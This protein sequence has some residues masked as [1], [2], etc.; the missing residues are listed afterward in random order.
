MT[1]NTLRGQ[2]AAAILA[3]MDEEIFFV[4]YRYPKA[5]DRG[6]TAKV[7]KEQ[8]DQI[9]QQQKLVQPEHVGLVLNG[10]EQFAQLRK[11]PE[12]NYLWD[13]ANRKCRGYKPIHY[14]RNFKCY[15]LFRT[16]I[17]N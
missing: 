1:S 10:L 11:I 4:E 14:C 3:L 16:G 2:A 12:K 6:Y 8:Y 5:Q 15:V 17:T 9:I 13:Y 7:T